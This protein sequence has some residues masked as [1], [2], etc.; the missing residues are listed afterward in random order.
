MLGDSTQLLQNTIHDNGNHGDNDKHNKHHCVQYRFIWDKAANIRLFKELFDAIKDTASQHPIKLYSCFNYDAEP[1]SHTIDSDRGEG[2][3]EDSKNEL[4]V[5]YAG[6]R[7]LD[8]VHSHVTIGF[9]P[10][11]VHLVPMDD[12]KGEQ[13]KFISHLP[14]NK[15]KELT[16]LD[17]DEFIVPF[18]IMLI[19]VHNKHYPGLPIGITGHYSDNTK[20]IYIQLR[21]QERNQLEWW[22]RSG[23][24]KPSV[25]C[26]RQYLSQHA[27][28]YDNLNDRWHQE[29]K[30]IRDIG[31]YNAKPKFCCFIVTNPNCQQRNKFFE[32]LQLKLGS[33][34][35]DSAGRR[36]D[37]LG[38]HLR[39]VSPDFIVPDRMDQ[40]AFLDLI[41]Q[42]RFIITFE[43]H[44]LAHYQTEK[45][46]NAYMAGT[47]PIYWGDPFIDRVYN[48]RT[49]VSVPPHDKPINQFRAYK[50]AIEKIRELEHDPVKYTAMFDYDPV[51]DAGREDKRVHN[52]L[53]IL[54]NISHIAHK[55]NNISS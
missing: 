7:Y 44:A 19:N 15:I 26:D 13:L 38:R 24:L 4:L 30:R 25:L 33:D 46:F 2:S 43:N 40:D 5:Y 35:K 50:D 12:S 21:E 34:S 23:H 31:L 37:S 47:V 51:I 27:C 53:F 20:K 32:L 16:G 22:L 17:R 8:E 3:V 36:V 54:S 42:Y 18:P 9:L 39:N 48:A 6:E 28:I 49:F 41:S 10:N 29:G 45:I 55:V 11:N 1:L 52:N 14:D